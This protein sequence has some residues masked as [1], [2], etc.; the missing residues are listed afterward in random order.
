M[1]IKVPNVQNLVTIYN[2][3][4]KVASISQC[5]KYYLI[6]GALCLVVIYIGGSSQ[7]VKYW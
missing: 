5:V 2:L 1:F 3:A 4:T 6:L 7:C